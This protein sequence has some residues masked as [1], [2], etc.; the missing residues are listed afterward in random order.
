MEIIRPGELPS[1]D[2]KLW[3]I[4]KQLECPT[5]RVQ[6]RLERADVS[7]VQS[8]ILQMGHKREAAVKCPTPGC[9]K[10]V[11]HQEDVPTVA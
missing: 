2:P 8:N 3:W 9:E 1:A 5:C 4:G 11:G 6:F 7:R 10:I